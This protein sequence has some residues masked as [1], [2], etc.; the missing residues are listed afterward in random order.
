MHPKLNYSQKCL[1]QG[2][3]LLLKIIKIKSRVFYVY[4][5]VGG[6]ERDQ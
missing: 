4:E 1:G 5:V 2:L 6:E 3:V